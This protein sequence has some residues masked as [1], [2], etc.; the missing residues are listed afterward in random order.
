MELLSGMGLKLTSLS[1]CCC[2][3]SS[4]AALLKQPWRQEGEEGVAGVGPQLGMAGT[5]SST[6]CALGG[7]CI[8]SVLVRHMPAMP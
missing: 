4:T 1:F 3:P 6:R 7:T 2:R 8:L 5:A